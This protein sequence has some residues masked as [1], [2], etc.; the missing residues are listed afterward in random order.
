MMRD[1]YLCVKCGVPAEEVHHKEHLTPENIGDVSVTLNPDNLISLCRD[2]HFEE[3]RGEHAKGRMNNEK[4]EYEFDE[5][6]YLV[7]PPRKN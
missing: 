2:C 6:G 7:K 4:D 5:D 1:N 3:H